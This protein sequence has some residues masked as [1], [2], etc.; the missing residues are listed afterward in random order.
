MLANKITANTL[1]QQ[2]L[3]VLKLNGWVVWRN[4]N[5]AVKGRAFIG[6]VG[7]P[8][9]I[10][11]NKKDGRFIAVEI[12]VGRDKLSPEQKLFLEY[13]NKAGGVGIECRCIE[14]IINHSII[15]YK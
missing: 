9:I 14:D 6:R 7:V 4:N 10:G 5:L 12:K 2:A 15:N 13:V 8:D 1:T 11:F 3:T